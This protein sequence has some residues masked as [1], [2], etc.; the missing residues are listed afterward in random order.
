MRH[1]HAV[2]RSLASIVALFVLAT[3][4]TATRA[5]PLGLYVGAGLGE[6]QVK[7][8]AAG[9]DE[10]HAGWKVL[11]GL[12]PI[13]LLGAELEYVDF[14]HPSASPFNTPA[15]V[16][17]RASALSALLYL[18]LPVPDLDVYA[19]AGYSRLQTTGTAA[20]CT[21][22]AQLP[23]PCGLFRFDRTDTRLEFGAGAQVHVSSFAIRGE[24]QR[25]R[26]DF[27]DPTLWSLA[28]TWTF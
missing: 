14:G 3:A 6:A 17:V 22:T 23:L 2:H 21:P 9:F 12:R 13:Q 7:V 20:S 4:A 27:G 8:D 28:L 18:P 25:F 5:D 15:D 16:K 24:Y 26:S 19:K 10:H 1:A 11:V